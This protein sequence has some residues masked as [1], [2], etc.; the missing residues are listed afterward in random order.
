[1]ENNCYILFLWSEHN[2][3][4]INY[5]LTKLTEKLNFLK[6]NNVVKNMII[7]ECKDH[8]ATHKK[9]PF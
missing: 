6:T 7:L 9:N 1:M 5:M 8:I 4:R 3:I 2:D